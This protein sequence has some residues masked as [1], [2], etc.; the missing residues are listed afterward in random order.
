MNIILLI[1]VIILFFI[2]MLLTL[3]IYF[4]KLSIKK[5]NSEFERILKSDTNNI[6]SIAA[7]DKNIKHLTINLNKNLIN[8]RTQRLQYENGNQELHN[9]ITNISHDLRTPLTS[10]S[11]YIDLM[12]DEKLSENQK[13]YLTIIQKKSSELTELTSQLF[14]FSNTM[15]INIYLNK[16]YYCIN[17]LLEE[18]L[19]SYYATFKEKNIVPKVEI[20]NKKIY[21][22]V[23]KIS[24]IRVF[25]NIL[26]NVFKYSNG[27]FKIQLNENEELIFSNKASSLDATTVGKIFDRYFS[28]ENAKG[29]SG[30]GLSIAKKLVEL[31]NGTIH[32]EY[33]DDTLFIKILFASIL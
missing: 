26:S 3:K 20:C 17:E 5:I 6:I 25:E 8:L 32:A 19:L 29:S 1:T 24:I 11:G 4:I 14:Y 9:I 15:D 21:K 16:E 28:V 31:N 7:I 2:C 12:K 23:N 33:F 13:K 30:L 10:I 18:V 22:L 27:D